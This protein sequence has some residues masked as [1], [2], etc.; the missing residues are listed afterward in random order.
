MCTGKDLNAS[1]ISVK[2]K[3]DFAKETKGACLEIKGENISMVLDDCSNVDEEK[4]NKIMAEKGVTL[5]LVVK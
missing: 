5:E 2:E 4:I 1:E 3:I